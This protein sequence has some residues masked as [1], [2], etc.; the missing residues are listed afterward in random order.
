M[1]E[2]TYKQAE[3]HLSDEQIAFAEVAGRLLAETWH[4]ESQAP[5]IRQAGESPEGQPPT[6]SHEEE[7]RL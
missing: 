4:S 1:S 7:G 2:S 3:T 6:D 5:S